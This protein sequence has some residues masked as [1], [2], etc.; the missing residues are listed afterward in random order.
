MVHSGRGGKEI[1]VLS[2][3]YVSED[4]DPDENDICTGSWSSTGQYGIHLVHVRYL[5]SCDST[6][7]AKRTLWCI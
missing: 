5:Y 7:T 2:L 1:G 3:K 4:S 6:L